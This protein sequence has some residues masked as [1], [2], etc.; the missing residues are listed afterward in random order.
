V[1]FKLIGAAQVVIAGG[2]RAVSAP[3]PLRTHGLL[4]AVVVVVDLAKVVQS[5]DP[6]ASLERSALR[7]G[8]IRPSGPVV[9]AS[10]SLGWQRGGGYRSLKTLCTSP[11]TAAEPEPWNRVIAFWCCCWSQR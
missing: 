8:M 3:R 2:R 10:A 5:G 1:G 11:P 7:A 4:V 9:R 6:I